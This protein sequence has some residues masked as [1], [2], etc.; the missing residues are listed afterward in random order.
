MPQAARR[1]TTTPSTPAAKARSSN[2]PKPIEEE[3]EGD[4]TH[5]MPM[6]DWETWSKTHDTLAAKNG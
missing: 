3:P 6:P 5:P 2:P 1:Y 4:K